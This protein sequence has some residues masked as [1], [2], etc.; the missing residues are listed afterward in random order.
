MNRY[1]LVALALAVNMVCYTDRVCISV[2][3]P[4]M[5]AE[6]GLSPTQMGFV[7]SIFSLSYFLG[8]TPWGALA[9]RRGARGLVTMAILGWSSFTALT[10]AAWSYV[11]L[12]AIRF[13]FG[14]LES[15]LSPSVAQAFRSITIPR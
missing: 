6:M 1:G 15:A 10:A 5:R 11:S 4:G 7:F 2:A 13:T 14:G 9:D 12:L 3:A 8:Q